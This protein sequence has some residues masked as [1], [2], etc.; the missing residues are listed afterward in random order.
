M[1]LTGRLRADLDSQHVTRALGT[2]RIFKSRKHC[3]AAYRTTISNPKNVVSQRLDS[4]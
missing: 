3:L 4:P 2:D 1:I